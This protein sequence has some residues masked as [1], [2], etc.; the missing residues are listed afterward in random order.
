MVLFFFCI[1]FQYIFIYIIFYI[2][3]YRNG[4]IEIGDRD[5]MNSKEEVINGRRDDKNDKDDLDDK[6]GGVTVMFFS[7]FFFFFVCLFIYI[8][9]K[10]IG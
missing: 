3:I 5:K 2:C 1:V 8:Y 6:I 7:S 10:N 4:L 9:I